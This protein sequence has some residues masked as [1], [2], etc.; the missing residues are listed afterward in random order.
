QLVSPV[1]NDLAFI[2]STDHTPLDAFKFVVKVYHGGSLIKTLKYDRWPHGPYIQADVHRMLETRFA[3]VPQNLALAT[4]AAKFN[5]VHT[6]FAGYE[7]EFSEEDANVALSDT[8]VAAS[9]YTFN[10][11]IKYLDWIDF[12]YNDFN[13]HP[14]TQSRFLTNSP[15]TIKIRENEVAELGFISLSKKANNALITTYDAAGA[16]IAAT[17]IDNTVY[18]G[19]SDSIS[20]ALGL[21]CGPYHL[22]YSIITAGVAKYTVELRD[23]TTAIS[24]AFTFVIDRECSRNSPFRLH[25][26]NRW[27]RFD[28][29]TF[30]GGHKRSLKFNKSKYQKFTGY[31]DLDT[32]QWTNQGYARGTVAFD[33]EETEQYALS[34]G[35]LSEE[36]SDWL[37][38]LVGSPEVYW[39]AEPG[40]PKKLIAVNITDESYEVKNYAGKK[41]FS[42]AVNMQLAQPNYR[43]RA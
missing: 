43:Q 39:Q 38:E 37:Q 16:V 14:G 20:Q 25:F 9:G 28:S 11:A 19:T 40:T 22:G 4:G 6:T 8:T 29:F 33:T 42:L 10:A 30:T 41:L 7:V 27:G 21:L 24:E 18:G 35:W 34:S 5:L 31:T 32:M 2:V 17:Q 12:D 36:E 1:Y 26:L 23:S 3:P 15:K 13:M